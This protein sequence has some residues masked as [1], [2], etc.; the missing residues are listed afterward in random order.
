MGEIECEEVRCMPAPRKS[1]NALV[2]MR[3]LSALFHRGAALLSLRNGM[4]I[5]ILVKR[6]MVLQS[7][8]QAPNRPLCEELH[9]KGILGLSLSVEVLMELRCLIRS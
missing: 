1:A 2:D 8:S 6:A 7:C 9:W 5:T 4:K 3:H